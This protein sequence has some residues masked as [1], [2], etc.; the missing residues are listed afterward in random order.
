M[1]SEESIAGFYQTDAQSAGERKQHGQKLITLQRNALLWPHGDDVPIVSYCCLHVLRLCGIFSVRTDERYTRTN[2][3]YTDR[4]TY[5]IFRSNSR[6]ALN[7]IER[8]KQ[9]SK[10]SVSQSMSSINPKPTSQL[11]KASASSLAY[12]PQVSIIIYSD[13]SSSNSPLGSAHSMNVSFRVSGKYN[14]GRYIDS[15]FSIE[16]GG[17]GRQS[18]FPQDQ[19][20]VDAKRLPCFLVSRRK[21]ELAYLNERCGRWR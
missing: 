14:H 5:I 2:I 15:L 18:Q 7:S 4:S 8:V 20:Y 10:Q 11:E 16:V 3:K 13:G 19:P 1:R 6:V 17:W 9:L 12:P 21:Q